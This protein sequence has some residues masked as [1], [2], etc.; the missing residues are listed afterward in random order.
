SSDQPEGTANS[1]KLQL[2]GQRAADAHDDGEHLHPDKR[3]GNLA[4]TP[5]GRIAKRSRPRLA[6]AA[7][8]GYDSQGSGAGIDPRNACRV[9]WQQSK[10][11]AYPGTRSQ[12]ALP[13]A[14]RVPD[15]NGR[16]M[17]AKV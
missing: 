8:R 14:G 10:S 1:A 16:G 12:D 2:A 9:Q 3:T 6:T 4:E 11:S 7:D 5:A 13:E 17:T 15:R